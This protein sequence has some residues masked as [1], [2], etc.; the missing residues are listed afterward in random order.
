M[1]PSKICHISFTYFFFLLKQ[2]TFLQQKYS[3]PSVPPGDWFQDPPHTKIPH[4]Q[5]SYIQWHRSRIEPMSAHRLHQGTPMYTSLHLSGFSVLS[6]WQMQVLLYGTFRD[7]FSTK[8]FRSMGESANEKPVEERLTM[9]WILPKVPL[10][11][12]RIYMEN[13][14]L[15]L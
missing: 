14:F 12:R 8:Y 3:R 2:Q 6:T 9:L 13:V 11:L 4:A 7:S 1:I 15:Q 5:V 10:F